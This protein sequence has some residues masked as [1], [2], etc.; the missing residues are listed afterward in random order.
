MLSR[1]G[2]VQAAEIATKTFTTTAWRSGYDMA[3]VD[4]LLD[5][6]RTA[7]A[8]HEAGRPVVG[9]LTAEGVVA[10][11]FSPT[12]FRQGYDQDEVDD[13]LDQLVAALRSHEGG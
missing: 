8:G 7:L 11:R 2:A 6:A 4:D 9:G 3:Q 12:K 5:R 13:Y 10:A 1:G